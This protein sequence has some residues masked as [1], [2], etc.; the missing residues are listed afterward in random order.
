M[1]NVIR[2][3]KNTQQEDKAYEIVERLFIFMQILSACFVAFAHGANEPLSNWP[4]AAI[5]GILKQVYQC[6]IQYLRILG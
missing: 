6:L 1:E 2:R 5:V 3:E 4:Y